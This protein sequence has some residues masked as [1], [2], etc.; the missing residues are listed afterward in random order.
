MA[1]SGNTAGDSVADS[2][3]DL[4]APYDS[5]SGMLT[6]YN[7]G[8]NSSNNASNPSMSTTNDLSSTS[9]ANLNS[10]ALMSPGAAQSAAAAFNLD[11]SILQTTIGS[12]LQSPAA[13]QMFLSSLNNSVQGQSL[14]PMRGVFSPGLG[15]AGTGGT[16]SG[17]MQSYG[18]TGN[19]DGSGGNTGSRLKNNGQGAYTFAGSG[20][21]MLNGNTNTGSNAAG[22][23]STGGSAGG[24]GYFGQAFSPGAD[25]TNAALGHFGGTSSTSAAPYTNTN[26]GTSNNNNNNIPASHVSMYDDPT[27]AL[28]SPLPM[29]SQDAL[30]DN[31][32]NLMRT[33]QN[34]AGMEGDMDKLQESID[35]LVRSMGL[36]MP[37]GM[38]GMG[39]PGQPVQ[40]Q[41]QTAGQVQ[42]PSQGQIL[43]TGNPG[44]SDIK[45]E[46]IDTPASAVSAGTPKS[47]RRVGGAT[48][49]VP[50]PASAAASANPTPVPN[51][52]T[53]S[54]PSNP[55][56]QSGP[57]MGS[58]IDLGPLDDTGLDLAL[59][60][61]FDMDAFLHDLAG[62]IE[63]SN[64]DTG[65]GG[66]MSAAP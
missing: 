40:G 44:I 23:A 12:L 5:S 61:G 41:T 64:L 35:Q 62:D 63:T 9:N 3:S 47:A 43:A 20:G 53:T 30:L 8:N 17:N 11:P 56:Q 16:A 32:A 21:A 14:T 66:S 52:S 19:N 15:G 34:A 38:A 24:S 2:I 25:F 60:E 51:R 31:Q 28:L 7:Y 65:L 50:P 48:T 4:F 29:P 46:P 57:S 59:P 36:D 54:Q 27:L 18:S 1:G 10:L 22:A 45:V 6:P 55:N 39:Q 42:T 37:G 58:D 13:A 49:A 26:D 33:Y